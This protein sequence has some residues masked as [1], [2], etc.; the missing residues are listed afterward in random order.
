LL[1]ARECRASVPEK[2][3]KLHQRENY[4]F[5][6]SATA[7]TYD[8][9]NSGKSGSKVIPAARDHTRIKGVLFFRR[10]IGDK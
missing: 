4:T 7:E 8:L 9:K 3:K 10:A 2:V 1:F 6:P 5:F